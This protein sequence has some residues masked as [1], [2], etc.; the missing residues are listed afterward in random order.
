VVGTTSYVVI[1]DE[2]ENLVNVVTL[3]GWY[4]A[5]PPTSSLFFLWK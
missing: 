4:Q 1:D 2:Y 5:F 3:Q